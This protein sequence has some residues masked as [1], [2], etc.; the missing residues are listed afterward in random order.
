MKQGGD[1]YLQLEEENKKKRAFMNQFRPE[2][3]YWNFIED[4]PDDQK[5]EH[6]L[7]YDANPVACYSD[8]RVEVILQNLL[9]IGMNLKNHEDTKW[10]LLRTRT[11]EIF[12]S[13]NK[14]EAEEEKEK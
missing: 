6:V 2:H 4:C 1:E 14:Q 11:M 5:V 3:K 7:R 9:E 13:Q 10:K 8:G 12:V